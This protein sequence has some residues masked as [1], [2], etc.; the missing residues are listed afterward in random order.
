M[1][2][3]MSQVHKKRNMTTRHFNATL[4]VGDNRMVSLPPIAVMVAIMGESPAA[5]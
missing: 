4:A 2:M 3:A 1:H 5:A